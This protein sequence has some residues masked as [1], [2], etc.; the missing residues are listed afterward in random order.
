MDIIS[1]A[2][3]G[4]NNH[5][6]NTLLMKLFQALFGTSELIL[7][8]PNILAHILYLI[9]SFKIFN[10]YSE[11]NAILFFILMNA[12]PFLIDFFS[13][14][15]GYGIAISLM[16][17]AFYF[18]CRFLENQKNK[19]HVIA[20]LLLC[21]AALANFAF[22]SL[23][24]GFILVHNFF[25][26]FIFNRKISF[27]N[28]WQINYSN[29]IFLFLLAAVCYEPIRKIIQLKLLWFGGVDGF[30]KDTVGSM[31]ETFSYSSPYQFLIV[32]GCKI[33]VI[34]FS[35]FFIAR[36]IAY[37]FTKNSI[38][39]TQKIVLFFGLNLF[40]IVLI[41]FS[42]HLFLNTP[43]MMDR[44]ALFLYPIFILM[45]SF[46]IVDL[47]QYS[48]K[49]ITRGVLILLVTLFFGHTCYS[50]NSYWYYKWKEERCTKELLA[51]LYKVK[52]YE[53]SKKI[54]L[55]IGW[56]FFSTLEF[57]VK[58]RKLDWITLDYNAVTM[59]KNEYFYLV[60]SDYDKFPKECFELIHQYQSA[61][62]YLVKCIKES[63]TIQLK[64]A[65]N[66][67]LCAE[68][69]NIIIG[70]RDKSGEWETF[71]LLYFTNNMCSICS[72]K[73]KFLSTELNSKYEVTSTR[74]DKGAWETFTLI[75]LDNDTVAFKAVNDKYL[76]FDEK[77]LQIFAKANSIGKKEKFK[78]E[79]MKAQD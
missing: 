18:Y 73:K 41:S 37:I 25:Y 10:R 33:L 70:N 64:A 65:N 19:Y 52:Q 56:Q 30:W 39:L 23:V 49:Y 71:T 45:S 43:F 55:G 1:Y 69:N 5:I 59:H 51:E 68:E 72:Y 53:P 48:Y 35:I 26:F 44:F 29:L 76:S 28:L 60:R 47:S 54:T 31:A 77:S 67:Y 8:L 74:T 15:R 42:Q 4:T 78:I 11:R 57:Y 62:N 79:I 38:N 24:L 14:A 17:T 22:I 20:M 75:K 9:F 58:T 2:N 21:V 6:L 40:L 12:N 61:D 46:L 3:P 16:V 7:R 13:L 27:K 63:K 36:I 32:I 34:V 50:L 66:K